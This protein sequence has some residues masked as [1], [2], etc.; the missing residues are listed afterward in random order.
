MIHRD[1]E[2][3]MCSPDKQLCNIKGSRCHKHAESEEHPAGPK[4]S[5][6]NP[7]FLGMAKVESNFEDLELGDRPPGWH[8]GLI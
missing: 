8:W 1:I 7:E 3:I 6:Q 2:C 4:L 5:Q